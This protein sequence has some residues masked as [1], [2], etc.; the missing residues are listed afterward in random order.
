MRAEIVEGGTGNTYS[1]SIGLEHLSAKGESL[2]LWDL[3]RRAGFG[4]YADAAGG[5]A[6]DASGRIYVGDQA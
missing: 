2:A 3:S 4:N 6:V 5:V 1:E